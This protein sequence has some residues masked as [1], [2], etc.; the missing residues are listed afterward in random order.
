MDELKINVFDLH[1]D[2][3]WITET[4]FSDQI[5]NR[6]VAIPGFQ[7]FRKDSD[8]RRVGG[9]ETLIKNGLYV[10]EKRANL[11]CPETP[12]LTV[13]A[14][15]SQILD[16]LTLYRAPRND[17]EADALLL[18]GLKAFPVRSNT[19]I[20]RDFNVPTI[21]WSSTSADCPESAF[22]HQPLH[23]TE[24]LLLTQHVTFPT[25]IREGQ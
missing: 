18:D 5:D 13:K 10:S 22:D 2:I 23:T 15:G 24:F 6:E 17:H 20:V 12:W 8:N 14:T 19:L 21:N 16:I 1:L 4:W 3:I 7:L 9:L 11:S 25:I